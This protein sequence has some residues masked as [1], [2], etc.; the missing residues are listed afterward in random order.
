MT[1]P[2]WRGRAR[3]TCAG[4]V[5]L[6]TGLVA[7]PAQLAAQSAAD[8][9][10]AIP[11]RE[12]GP[13]LMGGR[14]AD[15]DVHPH[16]PAH[17]YVG[18]ASG[19]LWRTMSHGMSWE[20]LWS[21]QPNASIG[22]VTL[23]P[24]NP[25]VIWV[26]TGEPQNRQSSPYGGGVYRSVDGGRTWV[27]LGLDETHHIGK[28]VVH[29]QDPDV[30]WVAA[31]GHLWGPNEERGVYRTTDG[32]ATWEK[33]LYI[34][35]NTGAIDLVMD[36]GDPRTI[37]AAMYQRRRTAFGF[38]A[39]GGGSGLYRTLDGGD[40]WHELTEGLPEGDKG[41]IGL[42]VYRRDGNLLYALVE[43]S[44]PE[45]RG[46][47]RSLDRGE[48]W[49][50]MSDMNPR[51]MYFSLIRIDPNNPERIYV[52][53]VIMQVSDDGG[54]TWWEQDGYW[55]IHVDNHA[56]WI[57]PD[58]SNHIVLGHDGGMATSWDAAVT[59]QHHDN[60]PVGQYYEIGIDMR[61][62]YYVCGGLQDNSS[63]CG[64][65]QT[66]D[67]YGVS[68][69]NW[70]DVSGGDGFY[71]QID[72]ND[73]RIMYSESQ[74]GN[75]SRVNVETGESVRIRAVNRAEERGDVE[76]GYDFNWNSPI[77]VSQHVLDHVYHGANHLLR[78]DDRGQT[79]E[80]AS[81]D[82]TRGI[83]RDTLQ[84]FG[85]ALSEPHLSRN[86][87]QSSY[88]TITTVDES[89]RSADILWVGTD[90]GNLQVTRD[91]GASW[92]NVV[93]N[94]PGL[95]GRRYVS[96]V[97]ASAHVDGR[98]Y[99]TFDG[100]WDDDLT[101]YVFVTED[102]GASWRRITSGLPS[103]SINV[104]RESPQ[105]EN[106]LFVGNEVGVFASTDRGQSWTRMT[107]GGAFPTVPVDDLVIHPRERD[108]VV[109]THGRSIWIVEDIRPLERVADAGLDDVTLFPIRRATFWS[110]TG[111]WPFWGD[112]W[113]AENPPIA[114][115]VRYSLAEEAEEGSVRILVTDAEGD[116]LR[117]LSAPTGAGTHEV[118]WELDEDLSGELDGDATVPVLPARYSVT[119]DAGGTRATEDVEVRLDP[120]IET[121]AVALQERHRLFVDA[122][123]L[124][125]QVEPAQEAASE[126]ERTVDE[127]RALV[128]EYD[129]EHGEAPDSLSERVSDAA[130]RVEEV[131][132][133]IDELVGNARTAMNGASGHWGPPTSDQRFLVDLAWERMPDAVRSLNE[134]L[135]SE[136]P[137]LQEALVSLGIRRPLVDAVPVPVPPGG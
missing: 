116:T 48:T 49:E 94:V 117:R 79:W 121:T 7:A 124:L 42:D 85:R 137:A 61:D 47:Y 130:E 77:V 52:G 129:E 133:R 59:W 60:I 80:E 119:L 63:W 126:A 86:D 108:L 41:R 110:R 53:G 113:F 46:T 82:L 95:P 102:F 51:P 89:P 118:L 88:G 72:P 34:D 87:G 2:R 18:F 5:V 120:R 32:G 93:G 45:E 8:V 33:V 114:A 17:W 136:L 91:G 106:L 30:A 125:H 26:G 40:S 98:A 36:P 29:P 66:L 68:N 67:T 50:R 15:L 16:N 74:G 109:G 4:L 76:E 43:G 131:S 111:G 71:N 128:E 122:A 56:M 10:D 75:I 31:V 92:T 44:T 99:V 134:L 81:P 62:P 12:L 20:P 100:H 11:F 101:P 103:H 27:D 35:E 69:R 39:S 55:S 105:A 3:S 58:N 84:I 70:Y 127:I 112:T 25:N 23:A 132:D 54:R 123:S 37:F 6:L 19:G 96:R 65:S 83:D 28:I 38:S 1:A 90:D 64:P 78:S 135:E 24:S 13:T 57:N 97:E 22:D 73:W 14:V 104:V 9:V 21:D 115:R 107:G